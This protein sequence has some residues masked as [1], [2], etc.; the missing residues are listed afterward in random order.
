MSVQIYT[1]VYVYFGLWLSQHSV[2]Y[3]IWTI[4]VTSKWNVRKWVWNF[5]VL[6]RRRRECNCSFCFKSLGPNGWLICFLRELP[7]VFFLLSVFNRCLHFL[8]SDSRLNCFISSVL[9]LTS[10]NVL[11][12]P[13]MLT[14]LLQS[15][16]F[17]CCFNSL[18]KMSFYDIVVQY[19]R[20]WLSRVPCYCLT[21]ISSASVQYLWVYS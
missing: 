15:F 6:L 12:C 4:D 16:I 3:W 13:F 18:N 2:D 9:L 5:E 14:W 19:C 11:S 20:H 7:M 10:A 17:L 8:F 1:C 21:I